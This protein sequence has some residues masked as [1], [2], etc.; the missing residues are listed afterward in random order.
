MTR[1]ISMTFLAAALALAACGGGKK[2]ATTGNAGGGGGQAMEQGPSGPGFRDGA[3]W[4]CQIDDYDPQPCKLSK[5]D[6]GWHLAKLLGSQRFAGV[7]K[8][9]G[10]A[11]E[12]DGEFFCPWG[13]CTSPMRV[14]FNP[15]GASAQ[16]G[17]EVTELATE[18]EGSAI[19]LR[20]D[21]ALESEWG[22]AG[23]G[24]LTGREIE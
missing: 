5:A 10:L 7:M 6:G 21:E 16:G 1:T 23:Y 12:F 3:L 11:L 22:G 9:V 20:Y 17:G 15:A 8:P 13:E 14:D 4:T 18:F 19:A 24:G 2:Q